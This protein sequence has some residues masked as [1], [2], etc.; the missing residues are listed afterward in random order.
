M[1]KMENAEQDVRGSG[2]DVTPDG[3]E[4][5]KLYCLSNQDR[6]E[7]QLQE[8]QRRVWPQQAGGSTSVEL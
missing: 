5:M 6:L 4:Q 1:I 8:A 7:A 2:P 3:N